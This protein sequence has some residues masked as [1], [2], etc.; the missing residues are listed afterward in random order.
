MTRPKSQTSKSGVSKAVH[1]PVPGCDPASETGALRELVHL[2]E[3]AVAELTKRQQ[4]TGRS[5]GSNRECNT[6]ERVMIRQTVGRELPTF[7]G[8]PE[9]WPVFY[10][11]YARTTEECGFTD[12]ENTIRLQRFL[13]GMARAA[14][15]P[16]LAL[17]ENLPEVMAVLESRFGRPDAIISTLIAKAR[18]VSPLKTGGP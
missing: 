11:T 10:A 7:S 14:V 6:M 15:G 3:A 5:T 4:R 17:P 16:L 1:V 13:R 12:S 9:E 2:L 18:A 8:L